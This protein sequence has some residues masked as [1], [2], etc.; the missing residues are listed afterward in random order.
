LIQIKP[1]ATGRDT[2]GALPVST[3]KEKKMKIL[4]A[5][6]GSKNSLDAVSSLIR[7][8]GWFKEMPSVALVYVHLPVPRVSMF[9][10]GPTRAALEKYYREEGEECLAKAR[11][12]LAKSKLP[13]EEAILVGEVAETIC[14]EAQKRK[15]DMIWMGTRGLGAVA[16]LVVGSTATKVLHAATV[17]VVLVK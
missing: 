13:C 1:R 16:G 15:C 17:P 11:R 4:M 3:F 2:M 7:H 14:G 8:T 10:A 6:D 5:V 12:L 9:G